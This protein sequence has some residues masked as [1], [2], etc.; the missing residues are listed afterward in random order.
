MGKKKDILK[1]LSLITLLIV[2]ENKKSRDKMTAF[3][4][5][6]VKEIYTASNAKEGLTE[7][8]KNMPDLVISDI[9]LP[10]EDG[11]WMSKE[12]KNI[13]KNVKIIFITKLSDSK[14]LFDA[15][16]LHVDDYLVKPIECDILQSSL[17]NIA[18]SINLEKKS[19]QIINTLEQYKDIVDERSIVSKTDLRGVITYVNKPFEDISGYDKSELIGR[20]HSLIRHEETPKEIFEDLWKTIL[21]KKTWHGTIKNKK[22]NGNYY[23]VDTIIKPILDINGNIEEFIALRN[24]ITDLEESKEYFKNQSEKSNLDLKESIKKATIYKKAIDKCN[25]ILRI[26]KDRR[27]TFANDAFCK[28]SGFSKKELIGKPYL[29]IRDKNIDLEE[30]EKEISKMQKSLDKG[31]IVEGRISNSAKDGS[32]YYCKYTIFPIEDEKGNIIEYMSIRHDIT[33]IIKLHTELE[34]TQREVIYKLGEIGE[35]RSKETGNHVKRVAEYSK[36]LARKIG[37]PENEVK[38]L[39]AASPMHD[40]GKVGIPDSILNKPGKLNPQEWEFMQSHAE[41]GYNILKSSNRPILKAAAIISYTHHEKWN[42]KGY[43]RG[44][45][46]E[47]IHIYGRITAVADVFDA[48]GSDRCYKKAWETEDILTF[49]NTQSGKHFDPDLIKVFMENVN[50]FLEIREKYKDNF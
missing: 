38:T 7:Y 30:Y 3:L 28:I 14:Y 25:I 40:I 42:G 15:I 18:K 48:L 41:I 19:K 10:Q 29:L 12:I 4:K 8:K 31:D 26:S 5:D 35:T 33:Q 34:E 23:I 1:S 43:P 39:F 21:S 47:D 50:E 36:V 44:L 16:K 45:K 24:D 11:I 13:D 9:K 20:A 37:M 17:L 46:K 2:E 32:V 22:K 49:L 27:I 6:K